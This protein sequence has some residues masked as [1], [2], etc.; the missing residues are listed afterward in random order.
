[1]IL[2][3]SLVLLNTDS[4]KLIFQQKIVSLRLVI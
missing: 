3:F 1:M 4:V 2:E